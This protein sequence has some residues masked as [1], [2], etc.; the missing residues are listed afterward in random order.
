MIEIGLTLNLNLAVIE[1]LRIRRG[2]MAFFNFSGE[3]KEDF[4]F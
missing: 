1:D 4:Y 2:L 3:Q